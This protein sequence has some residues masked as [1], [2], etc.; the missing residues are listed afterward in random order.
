MFHSCAGLYSL[1]CPTDSPISILP[2]FI[3][4]KPASREQTNAT[5]PV[6][7]ILLTLIKCCIYQKNETLNLHLTSCT[8]CGDNNRHNTFMPSMQFMTHLN[9]VNQSII[10]LSYLNVSLLLLLSRHSLACDS[11]PLSLATNSDLKEYI[12]KSA[13][14]ISHSLLPPIWTD[15][16]AI[17]MDDHPCGKM[18]AI[19]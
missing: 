6:I 3:N 12:K 15:R 2:T 18:G 11:L 1:C 4:Q 7:G 14:S 10:L 13:Q 17:E 16:P 9:H 19:F 8:F 5:H